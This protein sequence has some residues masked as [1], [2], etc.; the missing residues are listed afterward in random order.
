[1]DLDAGGRTGRAAGLDAVPV[2]E[3]TFIEAGPV[4]G[5]ALSL[6]ESFVK[7]TISEALPLPLPFDVSAFADPSFPAPL[8][9]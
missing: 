3:A 2:L 5:F 4:G 1:M 9:R 8:D 6:L 7:S